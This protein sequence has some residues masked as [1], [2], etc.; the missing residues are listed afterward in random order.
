[1]MRPDM[2]EQRRL[3]DEFHL[4]LGARGLAAS[5]KIEM[6]GCFGDLMWPPYGDRDYVISRVT[7]DPAFMI[8]SYARYVALA[9]ILDEIRF[10]AARIEPGAPSWW[11]SG[12][13]PNRVAAVQAESEQ[14][15]MAIL[16]SVTDAV[17]FTHSYLSGA[18]LDAIDVVRVRPS[19]ARY[20]ELGLLPPR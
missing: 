17:R 8:T 1:M 4:E 11:W 6:C 2:G 14:Y 12:E 3:L 5:G 18:S 10:F 9:R 15:E 19:I 16:L 13:D 7:V 20:Q